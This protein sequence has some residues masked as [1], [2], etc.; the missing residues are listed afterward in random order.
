[1]TLRAFLQNNF[2]DSLCYVGPDLRAWGF[3]IKF[4]QCCATFPAAELYLDFI[5][6]RLRRDQA[7]RAQRVTDAENR[8]RRDIENF[9]ETD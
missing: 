8:L 9:G 5:I 4:G 3:N 2:A 6:A 1:M 7:Q